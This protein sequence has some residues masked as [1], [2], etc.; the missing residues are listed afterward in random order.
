MVVIRQEEERD[1][2]A[3]EELTKR[4]FWNLYVPGCDEHY[5][6]HKMRGH[7]D[8]I[9]ELAHVLELDGT[10][11]GSIFYTRAK[12][13]NQG[14][15]L[16]NVVTF[17]PVCVDPAHQRKGYGKKLIEFTLEKARKMGFEHAVIFGNP[18]NYTGLGFKSCARFKVYV[19][20]REYPAALLVK[21]IGATP[22]GDGEWEYLG[23]GVYSVD[24]GEAESFDRGF[25]QMVKETNGRQEEFFI[26][27]NSR[28]SG[29]QS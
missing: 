12:L 7:G 28:I 16:T 17:G 21:Q 10:V 8:F 3:V 23:S 25:P 13:R 27:S 2:R 26:L 15:E 29:P 11:I 14:Q 20:D 1:Y 24:P 5:L 22:L 4:A 9:P 6:V 18:G 19:G